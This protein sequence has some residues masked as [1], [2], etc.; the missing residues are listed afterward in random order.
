MMSLSQFVFIS[1]TVVALATGQILFKLA[2]ATVEFSMAGLW[3]AMVN[4]KL[5]IALVVYA[6]AT[7]LWLFALKTTP[8]SIA[9]PF[10]AMAFFIVPLLAHFFLGESLNWNTFAGA[11]L[12]AL[13]VCVSVYRA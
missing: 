13:G 4:V 2:S 6:G 7:V 8:L 9:Y 5:I 11:A 12:I 3:S 1:L 10:T